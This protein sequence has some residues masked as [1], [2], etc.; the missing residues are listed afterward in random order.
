[1]EDILLRL[2]SPF[3]RDTRICSMVM[4]VIGRVRYSL[5]WCSIYLNLPR[6]HTGDL[7]LHRRGHNNNLPL[8]D[9]N[10]NLPQQDHNPL[11]LL[12]RQPQNHNSPHHHP[13][14]NPNSL[15]NQIIQFHL[16][17]NINTFHNK[18]LHSHQFNAEILPS[19]ETNVPVHH[20]SSL[21]ISNELLPPQN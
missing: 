9:R 13:P 18:S 16:L 15:P 17:P 2:L 21:T 11:D 4:V 7:S 1:M 10:S 5:W 14:Q 12:N 19:H 6:L 3:I 8:Q 20:M